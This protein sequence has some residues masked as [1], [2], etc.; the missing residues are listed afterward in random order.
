VSCASTREPER[1][2]RRGRTGEPPTGAEGEVDEGELDDG[3][4]L[5]CVAYP[6]EPF[7]L[8]TGETP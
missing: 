8:K 4:V 7:T 6:R 1:R 5:T 3:Y 2:V